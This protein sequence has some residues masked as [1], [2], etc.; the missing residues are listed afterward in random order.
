M[1]PPSYVVTAGG[2]R[3][4]CMTSEQLTNHAPI[5]AHTMSC[6]GEWELYSGGIRWA[7]RW[8]LVDGANT[9]GVYHGFIRGVL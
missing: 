4:P 5:Q 2:L 8:G 3:G 1:G 9:W 6:S 7:I